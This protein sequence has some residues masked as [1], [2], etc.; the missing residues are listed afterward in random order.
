[1]LALFSRGA[2]PD[3][4]RGADPSSA[5]LD[6]QMIDRE[7]STIAG[8]VTQASATEGAVRRVALLLRRADL[9]GTL[10]DEARLWRATARARARG[11]RHP[12][13]LV[14]EANLALRFHRPSEADS[15]LAHIPP[16]GP[17]QDALRADVALEEGDLDRARRHCE[18]ALAKGGGWDVRARL[19]YLESLTG[20]AETAD[21]IYAR[22]Q[23]QLSA[24]EMR[25]YS[26][27]ERQ[28]G[29][30]ALRHGRLAQAEVFYDRAERAYSGDWR[31][32]EHKAE[33]LGAQGRFGEA[34]ALYEAVESRTHRPEVQHSL[35][36][37]LSAMGRRAAARVWHE[38]ALAGYLGSTRRGEV[39]YFHHLAA[40]YA[41][42][43][44]DGAQALLW[45][46]RDRALRGSVATQDALAW[47]LH[48]AGH[49]GEALVVS[50]ALLGL[51]VQDAHVLF[52]AAMIQLGAGHTSR[53]RE[54]LAQAMASN[55]RLLS[56]HVHR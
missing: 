45:A 14:L 22:A 21:G 3:A 35:G 8:D 2:V 55:P 40:F 29:L 13:L 34:L 19:A 10:D 9:T 48:R 47:S 56:F 43:R 32:A 30:L 38:R 51:G 24:K 27:L 7:L 17:W 44:E 18:Q 12:D 42:V 33:L 49:A 39:H 31:V 28:R 23:D 37:L 6:L 1:M 4:R 52:R 5:I 20:N 36:D 46:R 25:A 50:Q 26:W 11:D 16:S 53:G 41:D 15:A 54:L